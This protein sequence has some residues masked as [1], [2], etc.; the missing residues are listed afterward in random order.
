[1]KQ[2]YTLI[3]IVTLFITA[4][5]ETPSLKPLPDN[6]VI[7]TFGDSLTYGT[8]VNSTTQSY[9]AKLAELTGLTIINKGIPGETSEQGLTR[10]SAVLDK[11]QPDLVIL[12]HGGNDLIRKLGKEQLKN[13]LDKMITLIKKSGAQV[14]LIGVPNFSLM[15]N[16]PELYPELAQQ[17][18]IPAQLTILPKIERDPALKSDPYYSP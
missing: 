14:I 3:L 15:L 4:C 11:I 18:A 2:A 5:S 9:P 10:L 6:A 16:V 1:M 7:L 8:G 17:Y 12:C 13:N